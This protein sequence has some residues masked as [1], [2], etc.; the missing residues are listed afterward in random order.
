MLQRYDFAFHL[1]GRN[2]MKQTKQQ[3]KQIKGVSRQMVLSLYCIRC[4]HNERRLPKQGMILVICRKV[5]HQEAWL[6]CPKM[7][8]FEKSIYNDI[9]EAI[10]AVL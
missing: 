4:L 7:C 3:L 8:I 1:I 10:L 9:S 6:N 2:R 5:T